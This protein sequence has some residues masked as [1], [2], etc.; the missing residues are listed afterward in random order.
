MVSLN[1][2]LNNIPKN[3]P[4]IFTPENEKKNWLKKLDTK[5][6]YLVGIKWRGSTSYKDDNN[7][8]IKLEEIKPLLNLPFEFHSLDIELHDEDKEIISE[9]PN[10]SG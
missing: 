7:R 1:T 9:N 8:S 4:Y 5:N 6:K 10:L 3:V 2:D